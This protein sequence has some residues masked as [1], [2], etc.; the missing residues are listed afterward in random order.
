MGD[1]SIQSPMAQQAAENPV[2][3]QSAQNPIN[4]PPAQN[5]IDEQPA[6]NFM[7]Q[8]FVQ[9]PVETIVQ[10]D[11]VMAD[12]VGADRHEAYW[13]ILGTQKR[14]RCSRPSDSKPVL[15]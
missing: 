6:Q 4:Q 8:Q 12:V 9:L 3:Q 14:G 15:C 5:H 2:D 13:S 11:R 7:A 10:M 1:Q